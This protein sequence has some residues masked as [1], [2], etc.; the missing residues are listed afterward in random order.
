[1]AGVT[2]AGVEAEAAAGAAA[3]VSDEALVGPELDMVCLP[4]AVPPSR[5]SLMPG[6]LRQ[7]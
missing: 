3:E 5:I 6:R 4:G 7:L 1:M 2:G